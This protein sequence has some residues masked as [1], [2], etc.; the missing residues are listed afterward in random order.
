MK[1]AGLRWSVKIHRSITH[2]RQLGGSAL[3]TWINFLELSEPIDH[4]IDLYLFQVPPKFDDVAKAF[5][6]SE[7]T[8]LGQ[9]FALEIRNKE[10][11]GNDE[12][13]A[14]LME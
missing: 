6:F 13:C 11:P 7:D 14:E 2:W 1:G 8:G 4:L 5:R 10:L 9:R 3:E 12:L